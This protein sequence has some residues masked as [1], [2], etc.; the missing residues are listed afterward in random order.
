MSE[1]TSFVRNLQN[2]VIQSGCDVVNV[3]RKAHVIATKL[4]LN[5]FDSWIRNEL[6]GYT[7]FDNSV[8]F[9]KIGNFSF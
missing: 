8:N 3:L 5:N 2:D 9:L 4:D 1:T 7:S 6:Y